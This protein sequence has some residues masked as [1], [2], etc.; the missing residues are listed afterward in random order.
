MEEM[1]VER[2]VGGLFMDG[3]VGLT[4]DDDV[5]KKKACGGFGILGVEIC[6]PC[7]K[8]RHLRGKQR[9]RIADNR[10][11]ITANIT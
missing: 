7:Q 9:S 8:L 11:L 10:D 1:K 4:S 5:A 6:S 3:G 2:K